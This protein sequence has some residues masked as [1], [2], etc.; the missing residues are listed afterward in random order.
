MSFWEGE[1]DVESTKKPDG[2]GWDID[3]ERAVWVPAYG[4][5]PASSCNAATWKVPS[6]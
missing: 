1:V 2:F 5:I 6:E 4:D 3:M